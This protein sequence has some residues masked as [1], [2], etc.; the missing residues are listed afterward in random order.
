MNGMNGMNGMGGV[1]GVRGSQLPLWNARFAIVRAVSPASSHALPAAPDR[2][3]VPERATA[4]RMC[5]FRGRA[6]TPRR[7][8]RC[9]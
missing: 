1:R 6:D 8:L 9:V 5:V 2:C 7:R 3:E 4:G